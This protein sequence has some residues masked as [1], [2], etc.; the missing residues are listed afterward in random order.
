MYDWCGTWWLLVLSKIK[1]NK[2][3]GLPGFLLSVKKTK[4][5]KTAKKQQNIVLVK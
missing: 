3:P 1:D 2:K 5:Y 4:T